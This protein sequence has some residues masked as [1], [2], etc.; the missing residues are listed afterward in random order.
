MLSFGSFAFV[1]P[2][3][4]LALAVLP[5]IWFLLRITPPSPSVMRF[6]AVRILAGLERTEETPAR[7]PPW[8]LLLRLLLAAIL[9][10]ALA[11]PII[12]PPAGLPGAGPV[13]LVV[14]DDWAAAT[15]WPERQ[16]AM[17]ELIASAGR[18]GRP[19]AILPTSIGTA[20][21]APSLLD[22]AAAR[23][24]VARLAP[25][26]WGVDRA[27]AAIR[28]D[29]L[30]GDGT[31]AVY[32]LADGLAGDTVGKLVDAMRRQGEVHL[33]MPNHAAMPLLLGPQPAREGA[34]RGNALGLTVRRPAGAT[35][36]QDVSLRVLGADDA[37]LGSGAGHFGA[38]DS[39]AQVAVTMPPELR[40]RSSRVVLDGPATAGGVLLLDDRSK[41]GAVGIVDTTKTEEPLLS[42]SYYVA[43][44]LQPYA[45]LR[46]GTL[47]SL[48]QRPPTM[49]VL[50]DGTV[51]QAERTALLP[52]IEGG[53]VF[54][55]FAGPAL[56]ASPDD[57]LLPVGLR[58]GGRAIGGSMSWETPAHLAP[59]DA[60][61]PFAGLPVSKEVSVAQQVLAEPSVDLADKVWARL[62]DGTPLVTASPRGHGWIVL[63]HT[64]ANAAWSNLALSGL[65]VDMLRRLVDLGTGQALPQDT[66]LPPWHL[67]DGFG[68][69]ANAPA[70]A[71]PLRA[72]DIART[73]IGP[74]HPPGYYG[75]ETAH[76]A[77]NLAPSIPAFSLLDPASLSVAT[78]PYGGPAPVDLR[79]PLLGLVL[80]LALIDLLIGY[81]LRGL[82]R[83]R[84][85]G[86]MLACLL[87]AAP[88]A[89]AAN[90]QTDDARVLQ[91]IDTLHLAYVETGDSQVDAVSRAG[92]TGLDDVL[93]ERTSVDTGAPM[94]VDLERDD[95]ILFPLIYWPLTDT[96]QPLSPAAAARIDHYLATGGIL[97]IDTRDAGIGVGNDQSVRLARLLQ[98][99]HLP[100]LT[101]MPGGHVLTHSFYL[102][103]DGEPG[104]WSN[105]RLWVEPQ[106]AHTSDGVSALVVGSNDYAAAWAVDG[107]GNPEFPLNDRQREMAYR[108]GVNL[109]MYA[110]TG[111]Y[112]ADQLQVKAILDRL[113]H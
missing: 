92:L 113:G 22:P 36:S 62:S 95:L 60:K 104:R 15:D 90:A 52:W 37:L 96:Q 32:W 23:S 49:L 77:L 78:Q 16:R 101:P 34:S 59:F 56:A 91:S 83:P 41:R 29:Q 17:D 93:T 51:T 57:G 81:G 14:D 45:D 72:G 98:G 73:T 99:V 75:T 76:R 48:L 86:L 13:V 9:I 40:N 30:K 100:P 65:F 21:D 33:L 70:S 71:A 39:Q 110:L 58:G 87:G 38:G 84:M 2:W 31:A 24:T 6:P 47:A 68:H 67:L 102:L 44:A 43:R 85:I 53:G 88:P 11:Q 1:S 42:R 69:L 63:V 27:A 3:L 64:T 35:G 107:Q 61:S 26:P 7:M 82:I 10:M 25:E 18:E 109:V 89:H 97:M 94:A 103:S 105:G 112:K 111:N 80:A 20:R 19:V 8:L 106:D 54:L 28:L 79:P 66:V 4:L 12:N 5:A 50:T 55:R 108:F 46:R 74:S